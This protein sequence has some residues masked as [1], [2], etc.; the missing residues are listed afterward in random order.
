MAEAHSTPPESEKKLALPVLELLKEVR[1]MEAS[2]SGEASETASTGILPHP[3]GVVDTPRIGAT[4]ETTS[5]NE[6]TQEMSPADLPIDPTVTVPPPPPKP[7]VKPEA[8]K[9]RKF[10]REMKFAL[11]AAAVTAAAFTFGINILRDSGTA[12]PSKTKAM[13]STLAPGETSKSDANDSERPIINFEIKLE[14][15]DEPNKS[16]AD[17]KKKP[18][19]HKR[20][21]SDRKV[22]PNTSP[23]SS[24]ETVVLAS[25]TPSA[26]V[27]A[28]PANKPKP[29]KS[30][31]SRPASKPVEK[32]SASP[33]QVIPESTGGATPDNI[34]ASSVGGASP[35]P[36]KPK[37]HK[38]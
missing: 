27:A 19:G 36:A 1:S 26:P 9:Q 23:T 29:V 3:D 20:P 2:L 11:G 14:K 21:K 16:K 22:Q 24:S 35:Q 17:D 7:M 33:V 31:P 32:V 4:P 12:K 18:D 34:D 6:D 30:T 5:V 38:D 25:H 8:P 10:G 28:I 37:H 13:V 15:P